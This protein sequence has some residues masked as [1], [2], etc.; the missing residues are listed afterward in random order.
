MNSNLKNHTCSVFDGINVF[1]IIF[2]SGIFY[3]LFASHGMYDFGYSQENQTNSTSNS[4]LLGFQQSNIPQF[5]NESY[6]NPS[7]G[8]HIS[9]HG[10]WKGV[11]YQNIVMVSPAGVHLMNGNLGPNGDKV[12]MIIQALNVS[13]FLDERKASGEIQRGDCKLLSDRYVTI[14]EIDG[15]ELFLK[16]GANNDFK[17]ANYLFT[18][19]N[20]VIIIGLKGTGSVFDRNLDKFKEAVG[21][22]SIDKPS[23]IRKIR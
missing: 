9:L 8:F 2:M 22:L 10:G 7:V 11:N 15:R 23:D 1:F 14:N 19:G 12:L 16:C 6:T 13:D 21:T 5:I 17:I 20:K 3:L 18:S 4:T